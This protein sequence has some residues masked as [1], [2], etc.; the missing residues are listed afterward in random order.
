ME[1]NGTTHEEQ[2]PFDPKAFIAARNEGKQPE[3]QKEPE[4]PEAPKAEERED[5]QP[6]MSRSQRREHN[7]LLRENGELTGRIKALEDLMAKTQ[8]GGKASEPEKP[9]A[10][11]PE[12]AVDSFTSYEAYQRALSKW[13]ARQEAKKVNSKAS[14]DAQQVEQWRTHLREM[15]EKAAEDMKG[16][17]DW[18]AVA[19]EAAEDGPEWAPEDHPQLMALIASSDQKAFILYHFA[20]NPEALE[21]MLEA[22]KNPA[23]QIRM[24]H[25]L[26]G[27]MEKLYEKPAAQA[28]GSDKG[29]KDRPKAEKPE[30]GG[31]AADRDIRKPRPSAE[32][33]AR[34]G[35]PPPDE[36][37]I[38]SAAWMARRNQAQFAR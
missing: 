1:N 8:A 25:R 18:D 16:L 31:S 20:K 27:R 34:G 2:K 21:K 24:F 13:D 22:S 12:P 28:A 19:K 30:Q 17:E 15:D 23:E 29:S 10:E 9:A 37:A 3:A 26:E 36:P 7:R 33:A 4:R 11:D 32:V 5:H 38:G 35:T 14:E 6:R